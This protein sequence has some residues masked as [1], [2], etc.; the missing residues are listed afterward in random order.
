MGGG[1]QRL[2]EELDLQDILADEIVIT[3]EVEQFARRMIERGV[4]TFGISDKPDEASIPSAKLADDGL[5]PLHSM[6]MK[7]I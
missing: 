7:V 4:L 3:G 6:L 1:L 5:L 2:S